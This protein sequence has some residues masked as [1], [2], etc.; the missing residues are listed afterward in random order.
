MSFLSFFIKNQIAN[1]QANKYI[2]LSHL[3]KAKKCPKNAVE[4]FEKK[5]FDW[6]NGFAKIF[7][8]RGKKTLVERRH[9]Q[10]SLRRFSWNAQT[11]NS[12]KSS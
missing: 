10:S 2:P 6:M 1:V 12:S 4:Y 8:Y 5:I 7:T 9:F 11:I 3:G